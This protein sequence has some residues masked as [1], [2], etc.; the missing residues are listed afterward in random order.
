[1]SAPRDAGGPLAGLRVLDLTD[2]RGALG[3]RLLGDLGADVVRVEPPGGAA[4]RRLGPFLDGRPDPARSAADWLYDAGKRGIVVDPGDPASPGRLRE[5]AR[6]ADVIFDARP[7]DWFGQLGIDAVDLQRERPAL[8]R[9][10]ITP[11]GLRGPRARWVGS[12]LVCAAAAGMVFVNG[13]PGG[14]PIAPFGLQSHHATGLFAAIAALLALLRRARTDTGGTVDVSAHAATA[15][16]VEHV[17]GFYRQNGAVE[18]RRGTLHWSRSF[19]IA[20]TRDGDLLQCILGDWTTLVEWVSSEIEPGLL[21]E[22]R[23]EEVDERKGDC[24]AIFDVLDRWASS[25]GAEE[26]AVTAQAMRLPFARVRRPGELA[27]DPQ[28]AERGLDIVAGAGANA[29]DLRRPGP[30]FHLSEG[31]WRTGRRPPRVGEHDDEVR[32]DPAWSGPVAPTAWASGAGGRAAAPAPAPA[33]GMPP[34]SAA[35]AV[36][37]TGGAVVPRPLECV[38]VLDFTWVVAGPVATRILADHGARVIK[39]ERRNAANFGDRRGGLSGNLNRGKESI[40]L[41]LAKPGGLE[42][43]RRLAACSDV[44][45]DNFSARVMGNLG[46]D[47]ASLRENHPGVISVGMSG[48][49]RTGPWRDNVS[50]GPTLQALVGFPYLMR[51]AGGRPAGWGYSWSD[52]AGG[53]MAAFATLVALEHR[54]RTGRGQMVDLGQYETLVSLLGPQVIEAL[55][56]APVDSPGNASQEGRAA[57]HGLFHCAAETRS[58]GRLDDDR[59]IAIAVLDDMAWRALATVLAEDGEAWAVS[60]ALNSLAVRLAETAT[61]ERRL[62]AWARPRRAA[63][64]V[65][66]LQGVGV[67]A[68]VVADGEDLAT[69]PQLAWRGFARA[70]LGPDRVAHVVDGL[71][72]HPEDLGSDVRAPGPLLGEHTAAV[73]TTLA[74]YTDDEVEALRADGSVD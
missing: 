31:A 9:I 57:P 12:D 16:A 36:H 13:F 35:A 1:M 20:G 55:R 62:G 14:P 58:G 45:I 19:R 68:A 53:M 32:L 48:F 63:D 5:L 42:A 73:L 39:I 46:L 26:T 18:T 50:Y 60:P 34:A 22:P 25:R 10:A 47:H 70:P 29:G 51:H 59:W 4:I 2:L 52:M 37:P 17:G 33:P 41:D 15:A 67:P 6:H 69:D 61:I 24:E 40:V 11:F 65:E 21:R 54:R 38:T 66:R 43:A 7:P 23:F 8:V 72:F 71:A 49:G 44:V 74:G 27:D 3:T 30:P 56:G 64:L 28:L